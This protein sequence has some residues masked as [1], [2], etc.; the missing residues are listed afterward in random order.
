M[1]KAIALALLA[2]IVIF[3]GRWFPGVAQVPEQRGLIRFTMSDAL[4][5][6]N[7]FTKVYIDVVASREKGG[8]FYLDPVGSKTVALRLNEI[9]KVLDGAQDRGALVARV[10]PENRPQITM[11]TKCEGCGPGPVAARTDTLPETAES[12]RALLRERILEIVR[13]VEKEQV[14]SRQRV[15]LLERHIFYL[16][17][18]TITYLEPL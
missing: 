17:Q 1:R 3:G 14:L 8:E 12:L 13:I 5:H 4:R 11:A 2:L 6:L 9:L 15:L 10:A 18:I 16:R 7:D